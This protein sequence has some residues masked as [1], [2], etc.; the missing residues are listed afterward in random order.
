MNL[1]V[2]KQIN[3]DFLNAKYIQINAKQ[4]DRDSRFI[5]ITCCNNGNVFPIDNET[6]YAY[7][8]YRKPDELGVFNS[9]DITAD[10]KIMIKLTE[11]MLA[12]AG[13]CYADL[14]IVNNSP[15]EIHKNT[16]ALVL[17]DGDSIVSTMT[18]CINV[19]ES[20]FDNTEIESSYEFNALNDLL[21]KA[22]EDYSYIMRACKISEENAKAKV[23]QIENFAKESQSYAVGGTNSRNG[24]DT[25]NAKYYYSQSKTIND[26]LQVSLEMF[27][28]GV[29]LKT[30]DD[31]NGN[32]EFI[33]TASNI[34]QETLKEISELKEQIIESNQVINGLVQRITTLEG[35]NVLEISE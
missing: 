5:L 15:V 12:V 31:G 33:Y 28:N 30:T 9:C 2:T 13:K 10:G 35:K 29:Q 1:E 14:V 3:V 21:I 24:E 20:P 7:V 23:E 27:L 18:F 32:V 34:E 8:R 16:G 22:T 25:D 6:Y 4:N 17:Q 19:I 11:Q 26:N